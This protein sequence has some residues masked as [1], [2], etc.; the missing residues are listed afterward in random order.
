MTIIFADIDENDKLNLAKHRIVVTSNDEILFADDTIC[1]S[2]DQKAM[3]KI[4]T[5]NWRGK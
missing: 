3:H 2:E 1:L 5:C 4:V